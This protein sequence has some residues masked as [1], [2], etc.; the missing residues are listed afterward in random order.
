MTHNSSS[1]QSNM[2]E[3]DASLLIEKSIS[4]RSA[5]GLTSGIRNTF[6]NRII[7]TITLSLALSLGLLSISSWNLFTVH[8]NFK[9]VLEKEVYSE[10]ISRKLLYLNE[11]L[12][13]SANM[14]S[15][16][17]DSKWVQRYKQYKP[18]IIKVLDEVIKIVPESNKE[19]KEAII[20]N[21]KLVILEN[22]SIEWVKKGRASEAQKIM[23]GPEYANLK[24]IY[25]KGVETTLAN[26]ETSLQREINNF[27]K[28]LYIALLLMIANI[29][30]LLLAYFVIQSAVKSYIADRKRSQEDLMA[31]QSSFQELYK[32]LEDRVA[33]RTQKI[34]EQEKATREDNAA[35]QSDVEN[36]LDVVSA[37]EEGDLTIQAPVSYRVTGLVSD[38]LNRLIEEFAAVMTQVLSAAQNVS[39]N[40]LKLK[41]I[42]GVVSSNASQQTYSVSEALTLSGEVKKSAEATVQEIQYSK[43]ILLSLIRTVKEGQRAINTLTEGTTVLQKGTDRTIQQMKVLGEFVGLAEQFVQDQNQIATQTQILALNA[44]LVATRAAEQKD[45]RKFAAAAQEF[46]AIANQVSQLAQQTNEGLISLEQRTAQ[47][48]NVVASVDTELQG[49][50]S[51]VSGFTKGVEDSNKAFNNVQTVTKTVVRRGEDVA[52]S[53]QEIIERAQSTASVM[54]DIVALAQKTT[55]LTIDARQQSDLMGELSAQL[56]KR[57]EF[58]RLPVSTDTAPST[59][60]LIS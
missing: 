11:V 33:E 8:Q 10:K 39:I 18:E 57:V 22:K 29:P 2:P 60:S 16:S 35:L 49:L 41:K 36:L 12:T 7:D 13:M 43:K 17:N 52:Q 48:Q 38:T 24:R 42:T 37:M 4:M 20:A 55:D 40:T 27:R 31:S 15:S 26:I 44:S 47:I 59:D 1:N 54:Q 46:E 53:S 56:L 9:N 51:L 21:D 58:F 14:A 3:Q 30:V 6:S 23:F 19:F 5:S 34:L 28:R 25:L 45:P 50:G 32:G